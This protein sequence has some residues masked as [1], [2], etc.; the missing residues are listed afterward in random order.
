MRYTV[1]VNVELFGTH[2]RAT[3]SAYPRSPRPPNPKLGVEKSPFE[4]AAKWLE[5][6]ENV[7]AARLIRHFLALKRRHEQSYS[8]RQSHK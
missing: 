4:I 6:D 8:F 3:E 7:N 1:N 2:G 5:I